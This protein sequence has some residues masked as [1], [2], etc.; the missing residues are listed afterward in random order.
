M[1]NAPEKTTIAKATEAIRPMPNLEAAT[2]QLLNSSLAQYGQLQFE[3]DTLE[4]R[5]SALLK[6]REEVR[7]HVAALQSS[8]DLAARLAKEQA[9]PPPA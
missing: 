6:R 4:E 8:L 1:T 3:I 7:Q 2:T 9:A 5:R